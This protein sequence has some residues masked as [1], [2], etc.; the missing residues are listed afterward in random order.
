MNFS[1]KE[2]IIDLDN[3]EKLKVKSL[4]WKNTFLYPSTYFLIAQAL[5][6]GHHLEYSIPIFKNCQL[7]QKAKFLFKNDNEIVIDNNLFFK[8]GQ[9][10]L[11]NLTC[12]WLEGNLFF[13]TNEKN[14]NLRG[15]IDFR[16]ANNYKIVDNS[17]TSSEE[18]EYVII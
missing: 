12:L 16:Y 8:I 13:S 10:F 2:V 15:E 3:N 9:Y 18:N 17:H 6:S 5:V 14:K 7:L 4:I 1:P 11:K